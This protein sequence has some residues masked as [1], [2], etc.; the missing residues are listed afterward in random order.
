[1]LVLA[2]LILLGLCIGMFYVKRENKLIIFIVSL[3]LLRCIN[4][5]SGSFFFSISD[6]C[7]CTCL[8]LSEF[9]FFK[10]S[11]KKL[12]ETHITVAFIFI[13]VADVLTV[14]NSS[15]GLVLQIS[16]L[17]K[18]LVFKY[19]IILYG[20][21]C[22]EHNLVW[23]KISKVIFYCLI[24]MTIIGMINLYTKSNFYIESV[25]QKEPSVDYA[26]LDERFRVTSMFVDPFHYGFACV[27]CF[28]LLFFLY[29]NKQCSKNTALLGCSMA[30]FGIVFNGSRTSI[31]VI[32]LS[33]M[34]YFLRVMTIKSFIKKYMPYMIAGVL[35]IM[36]L[37][38]LKGKIIESISIFQMDA[39]VQGSSLEMRFTQLELAIEY[40][41]NHFWWGHGLD[42]VNYHFFSENSDY[43]VD[44][45]GFGF[46]SEIFHL[47]INKGIF[48]MLTYLVFYLSVFRFFYKN[49]C[50]NHSDAIGLAIT[51]SFLFFSV[52]TGESAS[53]PISFLII[54]C[55]IKDVYIQCKK[56]RCVNLDTMQ[57][58]LL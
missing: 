18:D 4:L 58:N 16:N 19:L 34:I 26:L 15:D 52:A 36:F 54:G 48:G 2:R 21:H 32:I 42:F 14:V 41:A 43:L 33:I 24:P 45:G 28:L 22:Y 10:S 6:H 50:V 57:S 49:K 7:L 1:M 11:W 30:S 44:A 29:V 38:I 13:I 53:A 31:V 17:F 20:F 9:Y 25:S 39:E 27:I 55:F 5:F 23:P 12:G 40:M 47:M 35:L 56:Y 37:P 8:L 46:E 3:L 51:F